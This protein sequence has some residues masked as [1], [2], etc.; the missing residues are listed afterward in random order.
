MTFLY[1]FL[2]YA[3]FSS[4]LHSFN[5][6]STIFCHNFSVPGDLSWDFYLIYF[7]IAFSYLVLLQSVVEVER[8][9]VCPVFLAQSATEVFN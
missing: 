4:I 9:R 2:S 8:F 7:S 5:Y 3:S 6:F 1:S